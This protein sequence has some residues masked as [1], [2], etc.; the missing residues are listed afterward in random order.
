MEI[1]IACISLYTDDSPVQHMP[2]V[3][4]ADARPGARETDD[5]HSRPL[6]ANGVPFTPMKKKK[7]DDFDDDDMDLY[8][9]ALAL[10]ENGEEEPTKTL[11][12]EEDEKEKLSDIDENKTR[13]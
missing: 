1:P 5:H 11:F 7:I 4:E 13:I 3:S 6:N 12:E 2:T 10:D 9:E 8:G